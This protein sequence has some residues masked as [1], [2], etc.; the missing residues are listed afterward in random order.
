[1]NMKRKG[2]FYVSGYN[3]RTS[4]NASLGDLW[5]FGTF[6][7]RAHYWEYWKYYEEVGY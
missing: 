1:M 4:K 2:M 7:S 6:G 5:R 3:Q